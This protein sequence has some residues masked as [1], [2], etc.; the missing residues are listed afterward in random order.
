MTAEE[1]RKQ[2]VLANVPRALATRAVDAVVR[3]TDQQKLVD[4]WW[5]RRDKR[6]KVEGRGLVLVEPD[7]GSTEVLYMLIRL[8]AQLISESESNYGLSPPG[9]QGY[10]IGAPWFFVSVTDMIFGPQTKEISPFSRD[11]DVRQAART[12]SFLILA[13]VGAENKQHWPR[14]QEMVRAR[15]NDGFIT[16]VHQRDD[17]EPAGAR[18]RDRII[19]ESYLAL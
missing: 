4:A 6:I 1:I 18:F 10:F 15:Y 11:V 19:T 17:A 12:A 13:E 16:F 7:P 3:S 5:E 8:F 14:L 9:A 2:L